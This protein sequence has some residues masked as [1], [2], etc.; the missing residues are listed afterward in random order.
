METNFRSKMCSW[1]KKD[2]FYYGFS[3]QV[4]LEFEYKRC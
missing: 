3:R 4:N 1:I 2:Y